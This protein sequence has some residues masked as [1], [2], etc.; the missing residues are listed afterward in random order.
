MIG[1]ALVPEPR[2]RRTRHPESIMAGGLPPAPPVGLDR[3]GTA[4]PH[5]VGTSVK[6][7]GPS[8]AK[9]WSAGTTL[10]GACGGSATPTASHRSTHRSAKRP[11]V[12]TDMPLGAAS[13]NAT[14][15]SR[16]RTEPS[17]RL[18]SDAETGAHRAPGGYKTHG[19]AQFGHE[20]RSGLAAALGPARPVLGE[21]P[22]GSR[23]PLGAL[24]TAQAT[25][26][27]RLVW[28]PTLA[29][30]RRMSAEREE[31]SPSSW[32]RPPKSRC[33]RWRRCTR[34]RPHVRSGRFADGRH[35]PHRRLDGGPTAP[36]GHT[37][38]TDRRHRGRDGPTMWVCRCGSRL[39]FTP[40]VKHPATKPVVAK[41]ARALPR[42]APGGDTRGP[43]RR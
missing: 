7:R 24:V 38:P 40:W 22:V 30:C 19:C 42:A 9:T 4:A 12:R 2:H 37:R 29:M 33:A 20:A 31:N 28:V 3:Q 1:Q 43:R 35:R 32:G 21:G 34:P 16:R 18:D 11:V 6:G 10:R 14:T 41:T 25:R 8:A 36:V 39:R 15:T 13:A 17:A 26:A 5:F 27:P 23:S